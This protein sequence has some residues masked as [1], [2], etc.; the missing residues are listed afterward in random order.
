MNKVDYYTS[1]K[2]FFKNY[3]IT[4]DMDISNSEIMNFT[5][6]NKKIV[7]AILILKKYNKIYF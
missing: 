5:N 3:F 4:N 7:A 6:N 2:I 1:I